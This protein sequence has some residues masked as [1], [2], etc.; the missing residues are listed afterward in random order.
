MDLTTREIE[1]VVKVNLL[2][3]LLCTQVSPQ[4]L[5]HTTPPVSW[6][7]GWGRDTP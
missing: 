7:G 3:A 6:G 5:L 1:T 2:G 4:P